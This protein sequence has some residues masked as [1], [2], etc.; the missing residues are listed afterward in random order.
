M[1][2]SQLTLSMSFLAYFNHCH[3]SDWRIRMRNKYLAPLH[4]G[5]IRACASNCHVEF[6]FL[7][8]T[9]LAFVTPNKALVPPA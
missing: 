4:V 8:L 3:I 9:I 2:S 6:L 7:S 5:I 1:H